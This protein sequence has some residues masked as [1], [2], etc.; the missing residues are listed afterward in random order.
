MSPVFLSRLLPTANGVWSK[1]M[2][3]HLSVILFTGGLASQHAS[4]VRSPGGLH[5]EG[6]SASKG[7]GLGKPP[8]HWILQDTV[9]KRVV[10]II[11]ECMLVKNGFN[12]VFWSCLRITLKRKYPSKMRTTRLPTICVVVAATRS[13]YQGVSTSPSGIPAPIWYTHPST[14]PVVYL[15]P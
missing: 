2:F 8:P 15:S 4:Q 13:Q 12:A 3:L 7:E 11:L 14:T 10:H 1:V 5:P 6:I 9:N